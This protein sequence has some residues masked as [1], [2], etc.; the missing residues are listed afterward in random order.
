MRAV[1][2]DENEQEA[3]KRHAVK[4]EGKEADPPKQVHQEG[5]RQDS[6]DEGQSRDQELVEADATS[7]FYGVAEGERNRC[8]SGRDAEKERKAGS[9]WAGEI[10]KA[11]CSRGDEGTD[12]TR[13]AVGMMRR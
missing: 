1:A 3:A 12:D 8:G 7:A 5:D 9:I 10:E 4:D 11:C 6:G 13:D 2:V